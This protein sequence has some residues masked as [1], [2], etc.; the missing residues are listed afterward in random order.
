[1]RDLDLS[2]LLVIR[3][4]DVGLFSTTLQVLNTL[5]LL[6]DRQIDR[7]PIVLLGSGLIYFQGD[8]YAGRQNVWEYYFEPVV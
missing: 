7:V 6:E 2:K 8:G 1:M 5:Y 3:E 4:R